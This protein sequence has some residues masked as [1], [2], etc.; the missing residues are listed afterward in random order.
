MKWIALP[1]SAASATPS[2]AR[3]PWLIALFRNRT[4][5]GSTMIDVSGSSVLS[6]RKSTASPAALETTATGGPITQYARTARIA[7]RIPAENVPTSIS[8]PV[9]MRP[10]T[11]ACVPAIGIFS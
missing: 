7:P 6:T 9:G 3:T 2:G 1:L 11:T 4:F 5:A 8:N 10:T